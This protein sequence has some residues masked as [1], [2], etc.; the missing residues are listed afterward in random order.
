VGHGPDCIVHEYDAEPMD[1]ADSPT[2]PADIEQAGAAEIAE[3]PVM[4]G[5]GE[6]PIPP[7]MVRF[8][9]GA[10]MI[11][12]VWSIVYG[13]WP[14]LIAW[15]GGAFVLPLLVA[16][17]AGIMSPTSDP[18]SIPVGWFLSIFLFSD[19]AASFVRLWSGARANELYWARESRRLSASPGLAPKVSV[20]KFQRRQTVWAAWG[21]VGLVAA[22]AVS[23]TSYYS[24][25]EP[26][27]LQ[28]AMV[29]EPL[30]FIAAQIVLAVWLSRTMREQ[31]PTHAASGSGTSSESDSAEDAPE[32]RW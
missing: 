9:W 15:I 8:N 12:S 1:D 11:P 16:M 20:E 26:Y 29:A 24:V 13:V 32:R 7:T 4:A 14:V 5:V 18:K 31:H 28:W 25:G 17:L 19:A 3:H 2:L 21:A 22:V 10:F 27:G 23:A 30:V 6:G